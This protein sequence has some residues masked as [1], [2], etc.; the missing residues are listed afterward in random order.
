MMILTFKEYFFSIKTEDL[1]EK[2]SSKNNREQIR[3]ELSFEIMK[4][5]GAK[6]RK[7]NNITLEQIRIVFYEDKLDIEIVDK[8]GLLWVTKKRKQQQHI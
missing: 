3:N 2:I 5:I 7:N 1:P 8:D 6:F 4:K